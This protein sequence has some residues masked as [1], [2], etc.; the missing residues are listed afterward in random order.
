MYKGLT[1]GN[2][3]C[4]TATLYKT[5][6]TQMMANG[7]PVSNTVVFT[8]DKSNGTIDVPLTFNVETLKPGES[9]VIFENIYDVATE[10]EKQ[11]GTQKEDIEIVRH[12]DLKNK[13]QTLSYKNPPIPKT[14]EETSPVMMVGLLLVGASAGPAGFALRVKRDAKCRVPRRSR[15]ML[16]V[17]SLWCSLKRRM[18]GGSSRAWRNWNP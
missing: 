1:A 16:D 10:E 9:V 15:K 17:N 8:P 12:H 3:Y 18:R 2:T 13:D 5:N 14:G 11:N 7:V 4:A 6:G